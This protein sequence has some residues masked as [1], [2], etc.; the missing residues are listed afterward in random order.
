MQNLITE[1]RLKRSAFLDRMTVEEITALMNEEDATVAES[2]K[3]ELPDINRLIHQVVQQLK[4]EGRIIYIGAGTSGRLGLLDAVEV[5]PTFGVS[6]QV[7]QGII[8]GGRGAFVKAREGAEDSFE[9][10]VED[11]K[12][13]EL[14]DKDMVIGIA[15]SGRTPYVIGG[16]RY[17]QSI[18]AKTGSLSCNKNSLIS[19]EAMYP[20]ELSLGPEVLSGST[21]LK[22][23]TGQ[24]MVLNMISTASM[25]RMGKAYENLMVD[26]T[27]TNEK[28]LARAIGIIQA[29][30]NCS[31][32]VAQE[33]FESSGR[34]TKV[35]IIRILTGM[36]LEEA[37]AQLQK[38]QGF[39]RPII[40]ENMEAKQ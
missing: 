18:G 36:S 28:L 30:T 26:V 14:T 32:A 4:E 12:A 11:L 21:R 33:Y 9:L 15:A 31:Q 23:G 34:E 17:A 16:L 6:D 24:K 39:I 22:A 7:F 35:A 10:A 27:A 19:K 20:I 37:R 3:K 2:I 29:A 13:I 1:Q 8:A 5:V 38:N 40:E 25:V